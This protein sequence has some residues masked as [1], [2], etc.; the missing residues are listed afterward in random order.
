MNTTKRIAAALAAL[1][2]LTSMAACGQKDSDDDTMGMG[3]SMNEG[4][5][6]NAEEA[7]ALFDQLMAQENA[8]CQKTPNC[9]KKSSW[10]PTRAWL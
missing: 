4:E 7:S 6:K 8:I 1:L 9:G 3:S 5:P 10:K 2:L